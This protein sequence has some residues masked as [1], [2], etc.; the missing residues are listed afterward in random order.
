V[1]PPHAHRHDGNG[2]SFTLKAAPDWRIFA[3]KGGVSL[4]VCVLGGLA[5]GLGA[6]RASVN[7]ALKELRA[8]GHRHPRALLVGAQLAISMTLLVG[9]SLFIRS[10][11]K[12]YNVSAN[13]R[14]HQ[15]QPPRG[16]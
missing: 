16:A 2:D 1:V 10:L 11:V 4:V 6:A 12:L 13:H 9:A 3:F 15:R 14:E 7:P 8:G 5:P